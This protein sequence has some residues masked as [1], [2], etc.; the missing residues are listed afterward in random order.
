[1]GREAQVSGRRKT[2]WVVALAIAVG[3]LL[4]FAAMGPLR[5][6]LVQVVHGQ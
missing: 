1:M 6:W 5:S 4:V 2:R 3:A